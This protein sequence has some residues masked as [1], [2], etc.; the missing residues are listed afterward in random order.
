MNLA[1]AIDNEA[2]YYEVLKHAYKHDYVYEIM[3]MINPSGVDDGVDAEFPIRWYIL[4]GKSIPR[5]EMYVDCWKFLPDLQGLLS[6]LSK[7]DECA[8]PEAIVACLKGRG[9]EDHTRRTP[10]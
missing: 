4:D 9:A 1:Y 6:D 7:C 10:R 8:T 3:V 2:Y 5:I